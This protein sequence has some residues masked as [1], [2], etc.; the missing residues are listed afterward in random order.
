VW[1]ARGAHCVRGEGRLGERVPD[2]GCARG[3]G[4]GAAV[5]DLAT[6]AGR[7][8][9]EL[10]L[11]HDLP[12]PEIA[13]F[14]T[15]FI[16][17]QLHPPPTKPQP[18]PILPVRC[19]AEHEGEATDTEAKVSRGE[20]I[21]F[22]VRRLRGVREEADCLAGKVRPRCAVSVGTDGCGSRGGGDER[23][24]L[25]ATHAGGVGS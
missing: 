6:T 10:L 4:W 18:T 15:G 8:G 22:P 2:G 9:M 16:H 11:R 12:L 19:R 5:V 7:G 20:A 14:H 23:G 25:G 17:T 1:G 3:D 13:A 21:L 24:D